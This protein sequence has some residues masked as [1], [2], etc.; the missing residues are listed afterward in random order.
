MTSLTDNLTYL[1]IMSNLIT[2]EGVKT[3]VLLK[4]LSHLYIGWNKLTC[5]GVRWIIKDLS[6]LDA[7]DARL[8]QLSNDDK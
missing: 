1:D 2:D 3:I 6:H 4:K 5:L 7:L 8:N